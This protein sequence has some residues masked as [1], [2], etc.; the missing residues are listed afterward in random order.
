[1][2][3]PASGPLVPELTGIGTRLNHAWRVFATG[4]SF[5]IFGLGGLSFGLSLIL[6]LFPLPLTLKWKYRIIRHILSII[7]TVFLFFLHASG[8]LTREFKGLERINKRGQ[9]VIANHPSLLDVVFLVSII[10]RANCVIKQ[11]VRENVFTFIPSKIAGYI[12]SADE[13]M[14]GHCRESLA[15]GDTLI[16]F[17]EGTR[18]I[19]GKPIK[20][21]RG[22]AN[23]A[24]ASKKNITPVLIRCNPPTLIKGKKWYEIPL[25]PPHFSIEVLPDINIKPYLSITQGKA[26]RQLIRD[27]EDIYTRHL[28]PKEF[29][30]AF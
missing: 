5:A 6:L 29:E 23:I 7:F 2:Q 26:A 30:A 24:I 19:P 22:V 20:L 16:I 18:S 21:M 12:T 27:I 15:E 13:D 1:V 8:L 9:L 10:K 28:D 4:F 3:L 14:I 25:T 17:P 11:G